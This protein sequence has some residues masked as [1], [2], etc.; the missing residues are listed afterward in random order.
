M[1]KV[2]SWE[3]VVTLQA[4]AHGCLFRERALSGLPHPGN[5]YYTGAFKTLVLAVIILRQGLI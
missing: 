4:P 2:H 1:F 5:Q 3:A